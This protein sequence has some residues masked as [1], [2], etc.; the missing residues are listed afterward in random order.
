MTAPIADQSN[1]AVKRNEYIKDA[2]GKGISKA[3]TIARHKQTNK[4]YEKAAD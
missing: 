2:E 4:M 1:I 3:I